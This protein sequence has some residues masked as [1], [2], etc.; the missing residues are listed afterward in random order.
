MGKIIK[1]IGL[2][3][4]P[5]AG[6]TALVIQPLFPSISHSLG[7]L[8]IALAAPSG[9]EYYKTVEVDGTVDGAQTDYQMRLVV[10]EG[11][12][13]DSSDNVYVNGHCQADFDDV[14]FTNSSDDDLDFWTEDIIESFNESGNSTPLYNSKIYPQAYYYNGVTY[15]VF[16]GDDKDPYAITYTHSSDTW[17]SPVKVGTNPLADNSDAHGAPAVIVD[18]SGYIHVAF[19]AHNT[20]LEYCRSSSS[21]DIS[22]WDTMTDITAYATYPRWVKDTSGDLYIFY[23]GHTSD[24][25]TYYQSYR[26]SNDEGDS[27]SSENT[28]LDYGT[29]PY[30]SYMSNCE[31][32]SSNDYI[33]LSWCRSDSGDTSRLHI[34]HA[35]LDLDDDHMYNMA[36]DDLGTTISEAEGDTYCRVVNSGSNERNNPT[37]HLDSSGNPY[38]LYPAEDSSVW[39]CGFIY[40]NSSWQSESMIC[41]IN[42]KYSWPDFI[43][44]GSTD[45]EAYITV[46]GTSESSGDIDKYDYNGSW[47]KDTTLADAD[48][49]GNSFPYNKP[50]AVVEGVNALKMLF[51]S[52]AWGGDEGGG[53]GE[54]SDNNKGLFALDSNDNF[55]GYKA[56][57]WVELDSIAASPSST[58]FYMYYGN[59]SATSASDGEETFIFFDDFPDSSIDTDKWDG[60]TG[61]TSVSSSV[62]TLEVTGV[63]VEVYIYTD[64]AWSEG[65]RYRSSLNWDMTD[66]E[67]TEAYI[68]LVDDG[69]DFTDLARFS[70]KTDTDLAFRTRKASSSS[71]FDTS[72]PYFDYWDTHEILWQTSGTDRVKYSAQDRAF[73]SMT[74]NIPTTDMAVFINVW[75]EDNNTATV[76][77]DWVFLANFTET[78]PTLGDWGEEST[79]D[80]SN[81]PATWNM[82]T[83]YPNTTYWS[84][85]DEPSWPLTD[86]DAY[87]TV[88]NNSGFAVDINIKGSNF[89]GG[90]GWT[91]A[92]SPAENTVQIV[93]FE[94]GDGSGD[95]LTL[96]TSDQLLMDA[97]VDSG[98][99]DWELKLLSSTRHT[100]TVAKT[101]TVT[102]T[103]VAD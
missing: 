35:F 86:G 37:L 52:T 81:T 82:G 50:N 3:L 73:Y 63:D 51:C 57:F 27:W 62:M 31:Y 29:T 75:D 93:A 67:S 19:G 55:V 9:F 85:G 89:T 83:V 20:T 92:G 90:V 13:T 33:H 24:A 30:I 70:D 69:C 16:S 10:H 99:K 38:M 46:G 60:D 18:D 97:L 94:E 101:G 68:G 6:A 95:G 53:E 40:Y 47:S 28:F 74:T 42:D 61:D 91:L 103:A 21:E 41:T 49:T 11:S 80:I 4:I 98:D 12:G 14:R 88:T 87:F 7:V 96:T 58:T 8:S 56:V 71:D 102:I 65:L 48:E 45:I 25:N 100:D 54:D 72:F 66:D 77:C 15:I 76:D 78:E 64:N 32:D 39:K 22:S 36:S 2:A 84:S 5:I 17:S 23:R 1:R 26:V 59:G 34:Y 79:A 43:I 44:N